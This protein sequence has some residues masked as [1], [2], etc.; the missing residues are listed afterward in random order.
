MQD[1]A[2]M[3]FEKQCRLMLAA[4]ILCWVIVGCGPSP[5]ETPQMGEPTYSDASPIQ[6]GTPGSTESVALARS[7]TLRFADA[8]QAGDLSL[9][10]SQ[11][12]E[13][14]RQAFVLQRFQQ[15]F[16]DFVEQRINVRAVEDL[17][18]IFSEQ[19]RLVADGTL[20][21]KGYFPSRPSRLNFDYRYL[22]K[23][24]GWQLSG[25]SLEVVPAERP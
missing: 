12:A 16:G 5:D 22:Q 9:F 20:H 1:A 18:P 10:Y 6:S 23:P 8:V 21:L 25:I 19:P 17:Q 24:E 4:L 3:Q 7:T 11:T 2:S 13:E 14:F 15:A